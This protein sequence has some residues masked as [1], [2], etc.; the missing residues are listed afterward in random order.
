MDETLGGD[1][2]VDVLGDLDSDLHTYRRSNRRRLTS[3][4]LE[5]F[6]RTDGRPANAPSMRVFGNIGDNSISRPPNP[7]PISANSTLGV[8]EG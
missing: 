1:L 5:L 7:Q 8:G 6:R 2:V 3:N 4:Q